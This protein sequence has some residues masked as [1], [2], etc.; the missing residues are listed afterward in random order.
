MQAE[1]VRPAASPAASVLTSPSAAAAERV[2]RFSA[3]YTIVPTYECFNAC[4]YCNFRTNVTKERAWLSVAHAD[5]MLAQL[6][7]AVSEVLVLSGE[8]HP[9]S[10]H[11]A[12]W[13]ARLVAIC[14][15]ALDRGFLPHTNAGPLSETEMEALAAVNASMGLMLEQSTPRLRRAGSVHASAPSKEPALR[16]EQLEQAGRLRIPFTT[17]VLLG[18]GET[19]DER[20]ESL[21]AIARVHARHGHIQEVILQPHSRGETE[22]F[23][24]LDAAM[25]P[26]TVEMLPAL[27]SAARAILPADVV[28]Q[29]PPNLVLASANGRSVLGECVNAGARDFGGISPV[30]HVN[31][32]YSFPQR[33]ELEQLLGE[34]GGLRLEERLAV[35]SRFE[36]WL[37]PRTAAAV[38]TWHRRK[39]ARA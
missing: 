3:S 36:G 4:A 9:S 10:P 20:L 27:V 38:A 18:I 13:H 34:C 16:L 17:G 12:G 24:V 7:A 30:D 35:H 5:R 14:E 28:I 6:P 37:R 23:G 15:A 29:V 25:P 31:P 33:R 19:A 26:W 11:R 2:V 21:E 39:E 22:R 1:A 32:S 8:V